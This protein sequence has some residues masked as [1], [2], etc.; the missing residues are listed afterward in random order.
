MTVDPARLLPTLDHPL[1]P[2]GHVLKERVWNRDKIREAQSAAQ[3]QDAQ[4][5]VRR[6]KARSRVLA[7]TSLLENLDEEVGELQPPPP[8]AR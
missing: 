8:P 1:A 7:L 2:L 6:D 3:K 5:Q 4:L